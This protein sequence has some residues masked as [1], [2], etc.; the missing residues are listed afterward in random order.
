MFIEICK[1][2]EEVNTII[3]VTDSLTNI[4]S[5]FACTIIVVL[6]CTQIMQNVSSQFVLF[7][8]VKCQENVSGLFIDISCFFLYLLHPPGY[9]N[10]LT[11]FSVLY[12]V[13]L[14]L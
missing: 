3:I 9:L 11:K 6:F 1:R 5:C 13:I 4:H 10:S 7:F 12:E 2:D 8:F 14:D